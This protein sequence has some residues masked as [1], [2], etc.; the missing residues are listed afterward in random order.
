MKKPFDA[1]DGFFYGVNSSEMNNCL[2]YAIYKN[3]MDR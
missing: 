2:S 1:S 3:I